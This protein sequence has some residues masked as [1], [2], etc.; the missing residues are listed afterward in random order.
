MGKKNKKIKDL[1]IKDKTFR[2]IPKGHA[3]TRAE[4]F[5][6]EE[7]KPIVDLLQTERIT[8]SHETWLKNY[9]VIR[10][11]SVMEDFFKTLV[12]ER[13]D[14]YKIPIS[15]LYSGE[16][17][18]SIHHLDELLSN[19]KKGTHTTGEIIANESSFAN[20]REINTL[21]TKLLKSDKKFGRCG[22]DFLSGIKQLD[23]YNPYKEE[24]KRA[25]SLNKNW[26]NFQKT[27]DIRNDIVHR[28]KNAEL[29]IHQIAS[30]SDIAL[31]AMDAA[32]AITQLSEMDV[33]A[34]I[35]KS[36]KTLKEEI[37]EDK[38]RMRKKA[39]D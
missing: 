14:E 9:L 30:L 36:K 4:D 6:D 21:F 8:R 3:W 34:K 15:S 7:I 31:N 26:D 22:K 1:Y 29:S 19:K 27:F 37:L 10:L 33:I 28:M 12:R 25:K 18:M 23:W 24:F 13:V 39:G 17:K 5:F 35:M 11:V 38:K 32:S 20:F 2:E 16:A